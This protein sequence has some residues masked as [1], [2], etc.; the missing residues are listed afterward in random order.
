MVHARLKGHRRST[1]DTIQ[2]HRHRSGEC[3]LV[4]LTNRLSN[5]N[6]QG[7]SRSREEEEVREKK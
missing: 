3:F 5:N 2:G 7:K 1:R 4:R 6:N